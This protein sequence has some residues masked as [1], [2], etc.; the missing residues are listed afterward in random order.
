MRG[1]RW[2]EKNKKKGEKDERRKVKGKKWEKRDEKKEMRKERKKIR[3]KRWE[4][5]DKRKKIRRERWENKDEKKREERDEMKK[6]KR[7]KKLKDD[8]KI[9]FLQFSIEIWK[10]FQW[11]IKK[12]LELIS[13][14]FSLLFLWCGY[15]LNLNSK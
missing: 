15:Y 5:K 2:E 12:S 10:V 4:E 14:I 9:F 1:K 11:L 8:N 7:K 13:M 6:R 3:G